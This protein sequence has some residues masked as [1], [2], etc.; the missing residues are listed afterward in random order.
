MW[1]RKMDGVEFVKIRTPREQLIE[2]VKNRI[3]VTEMNIRRLERELKE[4]RGILET[5]YKR[6]EHLEAER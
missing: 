3:M 4:Q 1:W 2:D 5:L 6:L